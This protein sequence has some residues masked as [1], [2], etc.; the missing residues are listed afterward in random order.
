M[1]KIVCL[2]MMLG[3]AAEAQA[4][5]IGVLTN[6]SV[7]YNQTFSRFVS[8]DIDAAF[9][10]PG[11]ISR[12]PEGLSLSLSNQVWQMQASIDYQE[13]TYEDSYLIPMYLSGIA[14]YRQDNWGLFLA[15]TPVGTS[16]SVAA[17][18]DTVKGAHHPFLVALP[19]AIGLRADVSRYDVTV[20]GLL[21]GVDGGASIELTDWLAI[22]V[23]VRWN[24]SR[25]KLDLDI[26]YEDG[27]IAINT[28]S[29]AKGDGLSPMV[30]AT[31]GP[32]D[33]LELSMLYRGRAVVEN[34]F[35]TTRDE[36]ALGGVPLDAETLGDGRRWRRDMPA[37]LSFGAGYQVTPD[38]RI[39]MATEYFFFDEAVWEELLPTDPENPLNT[40]SDYE[41]GT[42][43]A[44]GLE[45]QYNEVIDL[46]FGLQFTKTAAV[47][48]ARNE[49]EAN[50]D[51]WTISGGGNY[52]IS[53]R[54]R[55]GIALVFAKFV[56][57]QDAEERYTYRG[58]LAGVVFGLT[59]EIP[60]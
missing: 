36:I 41:N 13:G 19:D 29:E 12:L 28:L 30:G 34:V 44:L 53:D 51:K 6:H 25:T 26:E 54:T 27:L 42:N 16:T 7:E 43:S 37:W 50:T 48:E 58:W 32:F 47:P 55:A 52:A 21:Y 15:F 45:L 57:G 46:G 40:L 18:S 9:Y 8:H 22:G 10:N 24:I 23:G 49:L 56:D 20:G 1:R 14:A 3:L 5:N 17:S 33:G 11:A 38:I 39:T 59:T 35:S 31:L 2:M 4:G 60:L